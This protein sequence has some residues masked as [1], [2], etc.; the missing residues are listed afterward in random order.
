MLRRM[1]NHSQWAAVA[2]A[3]ANGIGQG[4]DDAQVVGSVEAHV[5]AVLG[6]GMAQAVVLGA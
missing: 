6:A 5:E 1:L 2:A 4:P 3:G